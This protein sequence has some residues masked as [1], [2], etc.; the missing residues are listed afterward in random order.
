MND[1]ALPPIDTSTAPWTIADLG[2]SAGLVLLT[3]VMF[4]AVIKFRN[5]YFQRHGRDWRDE[6]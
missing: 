1:I 5:E 6:L 4:I 2:Y 3:I